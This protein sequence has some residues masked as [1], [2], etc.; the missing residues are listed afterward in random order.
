VE[1]TTRDVLVDAVAAP[2]VL[3]AEHPDLKLPAK[4]KSR[5]E[6]IGIADLAVVVN[7]FGELVELDSASAGAQKRQAE[8]RV[9]RERKP[10]E[11]LIAKENE[12]K[13]GSALDRMAKDAMMGSAGAMTAANPRG[14]G[15]GK[16]AG[17]NPIRRKAGG[18]RGGGGSSA[19]S[20]P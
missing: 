16:A 4:T 19:M 20:A 15:S 18:R 6:D 17:P 12:D 3:L 1:F 8:D 14:S 7:R 2:L 10:F 9:S 13:G 11:D 5:P